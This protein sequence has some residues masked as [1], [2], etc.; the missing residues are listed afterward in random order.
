MENEQLVLN[1]LEK[2]ESKEK[3]CK[4]IYLKYIIIL[5][6]FIILSVLIVLLIIFFSDDNKKKPFPPNI[7][8]EFNFTLLNN[9]SEQYVLVYWNCSHIFDLISINVK[10]LNDGNI[11]TYNIHNTNE[12]ETLVKVYYGIPKVN[13][14]YEKDIY[15]SDKTFEFI[16]PINEICIA[17]I[18]AS[19]PVSILSFELFNISKAY[20]CPIYVGLERYKTWDWKS[21]PNNV[22]LF[23][24]ID[25]T[26]FMKINFNDIYYGISEWIKQLYKA[27]NDIKIHL[28]LNDY[29]THV[30]SLYIF[31]NNIPEK[32]YDF[33]FISDGT[34]SYLTFNKI[35]DNNETYIKNYNEMCKKWKE[36]KKLIWDLKY[37]K[38]NIKDSR[39]INIDKMRNYNNVIIKEE[40]NVF[41]WLTKIEGLFAPNNPILL[42]EILN[43]NHILLKDIN[44][45]LN[46]FK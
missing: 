8:I 20:N 24:Y 3:N 34:A 10:G 37:Y 27:N 35:F 9:N 13:I 6:I 28:F 23:D 41:W 12:G 38:D 45:L 44:H 7:T 19:L 39:F 16:I 29:H 32:N 22:Y 26:D 15:G 21:L 18:I 42:K 25:Q 46:K 2:I 5:S 11:R 40:K 17:P 31:A 4:K 30:F 43:N 33:T 1:D 36:H 14:Y